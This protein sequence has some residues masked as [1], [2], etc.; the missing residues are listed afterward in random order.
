V[1]LAYGTRGLNSPFGNDIRQFATTL[2][3]TGFLAAIPHYFQSTGTSASTNV[4]GDL[5]VTA[6]FVVNQNLWIDTVRRCAVHLGT[7]PQG[8]GKPVGL[9]GF[10]MGAHLALRSAK[11]P[12]SPVILAV[13]DFFGPISQT[14]FDIG[15]NID[16]LP[17]V[18]IH[19]GEDDTIVRPVQSQHLEQLLKTAGKVKG[20]HYETYDY[21]GE[22]HG[23]Q[24][25]GAVK[26]STGRTVQFFQRHLV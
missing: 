13:V 24:S 23:F 15:G 3:N 9:L 16:R 1:V 11:L 4:D 19:Y 26:D 14:P 17:P 25:P 8:A 12:G 22:G 20:T 7:L 10:S 5:A 21:P 18:Q 6:A 2:A